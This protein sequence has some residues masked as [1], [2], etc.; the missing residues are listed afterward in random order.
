[1]YAQT[2]PCPL[3]RAALPYTIILHYSEIVNVNII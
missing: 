1:M 2:K 3:Y